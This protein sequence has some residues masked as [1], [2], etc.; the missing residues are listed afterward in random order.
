MS[1][2]L[3]VLGGTAGSLLMALVDHGQE[4][5]FI[6]LPRAWGLAAAPW[7]WVLLMLLA[8]AALVAVIRR[9]PGATGTGPLTGFHFDDPLIIVPSVLLAALAT[10]ILGISLGPEAPLIVLGSAI[11]AI[12]G[13]RAD[14]QARK[15]LMLLGGVA[16]IG[17]VFGNPFISA[18]MILEFAA[19]GM[20]PAMLITPVL[21]ALG[22]S[23]VTQIGIGNIQG[24]GVH[25]LSVPGLPAYTSIQGRDLLVAVVI[26]I[27]AGAVAMA[28]REGGLAFARFAGRRAIAGLFTAALITAAVAIIATSGFDVGLNQILFSGNSGMGDL[29]TQTSITAVIVILVGKAIVYAV[30][31]GGGFRGGPIFPATFLGVAVAVLATLLLPEDSV[32]A[33]AAAGIAASAAAMLKL[34]ATSALLGAVLVAGAGAAIAPFAIIG[35]TVGFLIRIV[36]D[37]KVTVPESAGEPATT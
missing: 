26:A 18:F 20:V 9:L 7:W 31:L 13:R 33:M 6:D 32:S 37:R 3:G 35:A 10:L 8:S 14:P 30:A 12:V 11:G 17:A 4:W 23:Y 25:S 34:P 27:V 19:V 28:A 2:I 16:A 21:V 15:A 24:F 1:I 5:V 22:A 29:I 36:V